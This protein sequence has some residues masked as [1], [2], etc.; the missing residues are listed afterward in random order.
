MTPDLIMKNTG[1]RSLYIVSV[2]LL[3]VVL[4]GSAVV[5]YKWLHHERRQNN[6]IEALQNLSGAWMTKEA[7]P[8]PEILALREDLLKELDGMII[9]GGELN[10]YQKLACGENIRLLVVGDSIGAMPWT[11]DVATWIEKNYQVSCTIKNISLGSN[12]S[13][14]GFVSE[15]LLDDGVAYDLVIVCYGQNDVPQGFAADYEALIREVLAKNGFPS[16]IAVLE[17]SQREYTEKMQAIMQIAGHYHLQLADTIEAF[18]NSGY[19]YEALSADGVHPNGIGQDVYAATVEEVIRLNTAEEFERKTALIRDALQKGV[20]F[21]S[22][23]YCPVRELPDP[24]DEN[25][26]APY[27]SFRYI[28]AEEFR[29]ISDTEWEICFD[30]VQKGILGISRSRCPGENLFE[31]YRNDE[32]YYSEEDYL[33][34]GFNLMKISRVSEASDA[35]QGDLRICFLQKEHADSFFG[36]IFT[37]YEEE[38]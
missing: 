33:S 18:E 9:S 36:I 23:A 2:A 22:H 24:L 12:T 10:A 37:D 15:K 30:H 38:D 4:I 19:S 26:V 16:V 13:Y 20:A 1:K 14:S 6:D 17:S 28:P 31:I 8:K 34:I 7:D 32:L 21:G 11:N 25:G 35:F 3:I 5:G 27:D 29:R